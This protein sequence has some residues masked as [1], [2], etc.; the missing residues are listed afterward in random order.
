MSINR[1]KLRKDGNETLLFVATRAALSPHD[2][3]LGS[4]N[5]GHPGE[6][7]KCFRKCPVYS[8]IDIMMNFMTTTLTTTTTARFAPCFCRRFSY[9]NAKM[10]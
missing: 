6:D 7:G 10:V 4:D 8:D 9:E 5:V 1:R 2:A 3:Y